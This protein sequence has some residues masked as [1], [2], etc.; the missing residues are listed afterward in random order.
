MRQGEEACPGTHA[1]KI[2]ILDEKVIEVF[3]SIEA[4]QELIDKYS[5]QRNAPG[6]NVGHI[7]KKIASTEKK[8][9]KLAGSLAMSSSSTA[10]KYIVEEMERLDAELQSYQ[11]ELRTAAI[12][13][14][15]SQEAE[16]ETKER[17]QMISE[18]IKNFDS[19]TSI[20]KNEIVKAVVSE[21]VW[22]GETLSLY[23]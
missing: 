5:A 16:I 8:I 18:L 2:D 14:R 9:R 19:F 3:K 4:D 21:C 22:D 17:A 1:I 11:A 10:A 7:Q 13:Q 15:K 6:I 12:E 20:E 23:L